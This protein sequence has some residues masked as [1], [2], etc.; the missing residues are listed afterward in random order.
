MERRVHMVLSVA[1][2][3]F[4]G[5]DC[6]IRPFAPGDLIALSSIFCG[7]AGM[8]TA[9]FLYYRKKSFSFSLNKQRCDKQSIPPPFHRFTCR[10][11]TF[12]I[13]ISDFCITVFAVRWFLVSLISLELTCKMYTQALSL[14]IYYFNDVLHSSSQPLDVSPAVMFHQRRVRNGRA[15]FQMQHLK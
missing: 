11:D 3:N 7:L 8:P 9:R 12:L 15:D 4:H 10:K 6:N 14:H 1:F 13:T 5:S 2:A